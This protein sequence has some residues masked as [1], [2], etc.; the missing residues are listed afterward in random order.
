MIFVYDECRQIR[1]AVRLLKDFPIVSIPHSLFFIIRR[2]P[3]NNLFSIT[4][5]Y[6]SLLTLRNFE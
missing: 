6:F 2:V 1:A 4:F 5:N 3:R